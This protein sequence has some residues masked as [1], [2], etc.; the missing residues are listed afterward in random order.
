MGA[1]C[2]EGGGVAHSWAP[3]PEERW[4]RANSKQVSERNKTCPAPQTPQ[5]TDQ[6]DQKKTNTNSFL[7]TISE[8][9]G[10]DD[11]RN[12]HRHSNKTITAETFGFA[13]TTS[14]ETSDVRIGPFQSQIEP[15][16]YFESNRIES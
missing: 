1:G 9:L 6:T 4:K 3:L 7:I 11:M 2:G 15:N 10:N 14:L 12:R 16:L 13:I 5:T 8:L